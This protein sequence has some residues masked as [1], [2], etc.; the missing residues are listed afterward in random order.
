ML[1]LRSSNGYQNIFSLDVFSRVVSNTISNFGVE[2]ANTRQYTP[3]FNSDSTP[4][5][6][7]IR[8]IEQLTGKEYWSELY[9]NFAEINLNYPRSL[10]FKIYLDASD[11]D[12]HINIDADGLYNYEVYLANSGAESKD[13]SRVAGIVN[14][15]MALVHN[16]NF[17]NDHF[18][19]SEFGVQPI[20]IPTTI[21]YN[22]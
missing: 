20:T 21:S 15:G 13:D 8:L 4:R 3:N 14:D 9:Y 22:G 6:Y 18:Q 16:A 19:N 17:E 5:F 1:H 7:F 11:E 10:E 2:N 12:Y